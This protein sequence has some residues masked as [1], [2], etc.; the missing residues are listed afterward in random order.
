MA[1]MSMLRL[2]TAFLLACCVQGALADEP[3]RV[4]SVTLD[5]STVP[6]AV[7]AAPSGPDGK[8][9]G[10]V[11]FAA[12]QRG[13]IGEIDTA[14]KAVTYLTLGHGARPRGLAQC[15]D[16]KLYALDPALNVI[17]QVEP[18]SEAVSRHVMPGNQNVDLAAALCTLSG[19]VIFTGYNG[20]VGRLDPLTGTSTL[21]EAL[22]GR[23]AWAL[24]LH[25][26]GS[27]WATSYA[28]NE[29]IRIDPLT[30]RQEAIPLP[31]SVIGPKGIA[32]DGSG[33]I[34]ITGYR[35]GHVARFDPRR[36]GWDSWK[37][38]G[39]GAKPYAILADGKGGIFVTDTGR[40]LLLRFDPA[41]GGVIGETEL[42]ARSNARAMAMRG[43]EIWIAEMAAD[44]LVIVE[45]SPGPSQ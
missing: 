30:L 11:W 23:G 44:R 10:V 19:Q 4:T 28:Q 2:T 9:G 39:A 36:N 26:N 38:N 33:R 29:L 14:T 32:I 3:Y 12:S 31:T 43:S 18:G 25:R 42:G 27:V 8:T 22:G 15:P 37:I 16:G 41:N 17:H 40:D 1:A 45:T 21:V 13:S 35:S 6:Q 7:V 24:A 20:Y 34:W 5:G